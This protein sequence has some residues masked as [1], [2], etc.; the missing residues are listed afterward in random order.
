MRISKR[1]RAL[2]EDAHTEDGQRLVGDAGKLAVLRGG[3]GLEAV[4]QMN[5]LV[6]MAHHNYGQGRSD[7]LQAE[8]DEYHRH[9]E[10]FRESPNPSKSR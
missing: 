2:R 6:K 4:G 5:D 7:T 3:N 8:P 1:E 10:P 9:D